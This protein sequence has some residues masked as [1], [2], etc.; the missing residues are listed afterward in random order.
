MPKSCR[1]I[2]VAAVT[3]IVHN[4]GSQRLV[5]SQKAAISPTGSITG[6]SEQA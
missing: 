1:T 5:E 2:S 3:F 4:S 6:F